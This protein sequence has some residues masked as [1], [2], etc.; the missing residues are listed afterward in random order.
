MANTTYVDRYITDGKK[1]VI[2]LHNIYDTVLVGDI[3]DENHIYRIPID[4]FFLKH[5]AEL[6]STIQWY[7]VPESMFYKPKLLSLELY[8]TTELWLAL[9]R[10][11]GFKNVTEFCYPIIKVYN[12]NMLK[13]IMK[14]FFKRERKI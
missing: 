13:E 8:G 5:K 12:P 7:T 1:E 2:S 14:V 3:N 11:N 4:D 9:L 6:E 10:V